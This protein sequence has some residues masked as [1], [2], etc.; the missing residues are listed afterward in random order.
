VSATMSS[1]CFAII[2][3]SASRVLHNQVF[4]SVMRAPMSWFD[5]QPTGRILSRFTGDLDQVDVALPFSLE[6]SIDLLTQCVLAVIL[7]VIF[8]P[9]FLIAIPPVLLVFWLVTGYF[10]RAVRELKRLD[11]I[12]RSPLVSHIQ[13]VM[14]GLSSI[15]A[16]GQQE[17]Y[18]EAARHV[19]DQQTKSFFWFYALNRWVGIR[20]D[21]I[22]TFVAF[23][24]VV[25]CVAS[26][27]SL[28]PGLA[29]LTVLYALRTAG[30]FQ[31][32][33][34]QQAETEAY[35][36]AVERLRHYT[37]AI[38]H[39]TMTTGTEYSESE[40]L[41]LLK[42]GATAPDAVTMK[43]ELPLHGRELMASTRAATALDD[44][45]F[46]GGCAF[47][48]WY[49]R[50]WNQAILREAWPR[51]GTIELRGVSVRYRANLPLVLRDLNLRIRGGLRVGVVGRTGSGKTTL[52]L[53]LMRLL[54]LS[55]GQIIIDDLD[56]S[57]INLYQLR[58]HVAVI[59][60]V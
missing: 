13:A 32:A 34:R 9:W 14:A 51:V 54:E 44:E 3:V 16:Y 10:R 8:L 36:T 11:S 56:I 30:V 33:L 47:P 40:V 49:S 35:L 46:A 29:G 7:I 15:R 31:F 53:A 37:T 27:S 39:E 18:I 12:S 17:R 28:E 20:L 23:I 38:P 41:S 60:Q 45:K 50:T 6:N 25:L 24:T 2:S 43:V 55:S 26:R 5:T 59:P 4:A 57:R 1:L 48:G 58:S 21:W 52:S 22:T 42:A 19:I